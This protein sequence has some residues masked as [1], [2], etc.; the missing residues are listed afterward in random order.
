MPFNIG[1]PELIIILVIALLVL[2]P[3]GAEEIFEGMCAGQLLRAPKGGAGFGY[4]PLFFHEPFGCTFGEA[5]IGDKML[6]SHRA[7][8]LNAMFAFLRQQLACVKNHGFALAVQ[9][10]HCPLRGWLLFLKHGKLAI[11]AAAGQ[12]KSR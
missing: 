4:D 6:V 1:A 8:A 9:P 7:Q 12:H 10:G 3:G 11:C 2:G 5:P